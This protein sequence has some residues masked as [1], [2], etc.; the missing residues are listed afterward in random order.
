MSGVN[1]V[2]LLGRLG[3]DPETKTVNGDTTITNFRVATSKEWKDEA[4]EKQERTEWHRVVAFRKL[5]EIAGKY[6]QKGREV[7][8]EGEI[9]TRSWEHEGV[10]KYMT[11]IVAQNIQ[12]IGAKPAVPETNLSDIVAEASFGQPIEEPTPF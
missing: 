10:K 3:A 12:F 8:V 7:Y 2:I 5:A 1:R 9:Q 6:L 11:E 4:G